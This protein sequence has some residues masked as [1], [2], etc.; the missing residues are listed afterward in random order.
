MGGEDDAVAE[1]RRFARFGHQFVFWCC[2]V[3]RGSTGL[4]RSEAFGSAAIDAPE[5]VKP[6]AG[7][8]G[9]AGGR[10]ERVKPVAGPVDS[11]QRRPSCPTGASPRPRRALL[12]HSSRGLARHPARRAT[13]SD[14]VHRGGCI[15]GGV[16]R[17]ALPVRRREVAAHIG[18]ASSEEHAKPDDADEGGDLPRPS[19]FSWCRRRASRHGRS[20]RRP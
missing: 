6:V 5:R 7:F 4:E 11:R 17:R 1:G 13:R 3:L 15:R 14:E 19:Q 8:A 20:A 16:L 10:L 2:K 12:D 9:V 18:R